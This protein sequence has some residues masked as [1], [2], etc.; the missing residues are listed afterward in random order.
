VKRAYVHPDEAGR[1]RF[2]ALL[3]AVQGYEPLDVRASRYVPK[4]QAYITTV[5]PEELE[6]PQE[7]A[8]TGTGDTPGIL[9]T[10]IETGRE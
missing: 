5:D 3:L 10:P 2:A 8:V 9:P 6:E 4:G 1:V 7:V